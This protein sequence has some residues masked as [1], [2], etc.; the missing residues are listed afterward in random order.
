MTYFSQSIGLLSWK[1]LFHLLRKAL[2][3]TRWHLVW[4]TGCVVLALQIVGIFLAHKSSDEPK[5]K[6]YV[7]SAQ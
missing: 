2:V 3:Y 7:R 6:H 5:A 4:S 1:Y